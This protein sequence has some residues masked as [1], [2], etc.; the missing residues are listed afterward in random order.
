M[1]LVLS[2][3]VKSVAPG[4][5]IRS[6]MTVWYFHNRSRLGECKR[7]AAWADPSGS[8]VHRKESQSG[9]EEEE[10]WERA[11]EEAAAEGEKREGERASGSTGEAPGRGRR[12]SEATDPGVPTEAPGDEPVHLAPDTRTA[13]R[14]GSCGTRGFCVSQGFGVGS[15]GAFQTPPQSRV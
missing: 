9:E 15:R 12:T 4:S 6:V 13:T 8:N 7:E 11:G 1:T 3:P 14:T 5:A 10:Q 2:S